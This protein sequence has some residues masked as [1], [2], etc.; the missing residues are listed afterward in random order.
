[1]RYIDEHMHAVLAFFQTDTRISVSN[2]H[3]T[4]IVGEGANPVMYRD[5]RHHITRYYQ[6]KIHYGEKSAMQIRI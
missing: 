4:I 1:M 6:G 2:V 5:F 3:L